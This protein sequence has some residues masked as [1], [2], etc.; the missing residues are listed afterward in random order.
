LL[1]YSGGPD[2][3]ALLYALLECDVKPHL[4]HVD[5]GWREES[6]EEAEMLRKE[7]VELGCPFFSVRLNNV[8]KSEDAARRARLSYFFSHFA[9][10]EALL[11]A[12]QA[13]DLAET[14]LKRIL[15]GAHLPNLGG[16]QPVSS[17]HELTI[18]RPLLYVRRS[19]IIEFLEERGLHPLLDSSN[20]DTAYLRARMRLEIFPFLNEKFGKETT[21]NLALLSERATELKDY[22][23]RQIA[24][25]PIHKGP[26]GHWST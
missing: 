20:L 11:L 7:A 26:W 10:Y 23:D 25:V 8:E 16:M 24:S 15:E 2:S 3:K 1:G 14:V 9:P 19:E 21:E 12:H 17:Q 6:E 13:D 5:H 22:L 4:A 18:W